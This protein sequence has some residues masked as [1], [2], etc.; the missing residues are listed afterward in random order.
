MTKQNPNNKTLRLAATAVSVLALCGT[1]QAQ[2]YWDSNNSTGGFGTAGG[3]WAAPTTNSASQGWSSS[4]TGS[5]ALSGTTTTNNTSALNF[6]TSANQLSTG[7]ITV[8]GSVEANSL[9]FVSSGGSNNTTLSGGNITLGGTTPSI[10]VTNIANTAATTQT[11]AS[12]IILGA[13][14]TWTVNSGGATGT[15]TL[16]ASGRIS[17]GFGIT[18]SGNGTLSLNGNNT[19]TGGT[20][21]NAGRL[22][23]R[24][25]NALGTGNVTIASGAFAGVQNAV[26]ISNNFIIAGNGT[27]NG[28]IQ[29]TPTGSATLSG[30]VTLS[31]NAM[32]GARSTAGGLNFTLT[33]GITSNGTDRTLTLNTFGST[34]IANNQLTIST[35]SV[36]LGTGG[37]LDIG[38]GMNAGGTATFNINVASNTWG[39][40]IVRGLATAAASTNATLNLGAV[41]ALGSS[42]SVLQLGSLNTALEGIT[43]NLNGNSQTIGGLRSFGSTGSASANGTRTVTS[44][45]AAT[46]TIDNSSGTNYLYDGVITGAISLTKNGNATQTL[47]GTNTYSGTT[48][49]NQGVLNIT[50]NSTLPGLSTNGRYSVANG[51]T[52]AVS[53]A[54]TDADIASMLGTTNFADGA[55]IGF[56]TSSGT[57]TYSSNLTVTSQGALGL[58]KL[59]SNYLTLTG[60]NSYTGTTTINGGTLR[61]I[62]NATH[63]LSGLITGSGNLEQGNGSAGNARDMTI[64]ND[65]NDF[66]GQFRADG[67]HGSRL[68]FTSIADYGT[69]SAL[70]RGTAGTAI[71]LSNGFLVYTGTSNSTSNRTWAGVN[72]NQIQNNSAS[73]VLTLSGNYSHS[74]T[75]GTLTLS[76]SNT[77]ANT[78]GGRIS[79]A[80]SG[81][82]SLLNLT[83]A[84]AG[85]W[86]LSGNNTYTGNTTV[87]LGALNISHS[88]ALGV[89]GALGSSGTT[90]SSG[91]AL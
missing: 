45:T 47:S 35:N 15:A 54:V 59:G 18:K 50:S 74:T 58:T 81:V 44:A 76:G 72:S 51:A 14:Q 43:V 1:A 84:G 75:N 22:D 40:T 9:T 39:T 80:A 49:I 28:A 70:G 16:T 61:F 7:T 90:V 17:G 79:A 46:L 41:N 19:Y 32:I 82:G 69:A 34:T 6:G 24:N 33:G 63:T 68:I 78:F 30:L 55:A 85:T 66:T 87:T 29:A 88:N 91:A 52:L 8:S 10:T 31:D 57:R 4:S 38:H 73:G 83:K 48:T 25:A 77:G 65:A 27:G 71:G 62:G 42:S 37:I 5:T 11:I 89:A 20:A 3:T 12:N 26:T 23:I 2:L 64:T 53:N 36:N 86:I 56:D 60:N 13:N 67:G 21:I